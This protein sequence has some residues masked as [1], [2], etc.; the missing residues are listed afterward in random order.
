MITLSLTA[1]SGTNTGTLS[2]QNDLNTS[3]QLT[4]E[5]ADQVAETFLKAWQETDYVTMYS[6]I[7]PNSRDAYTETEFTDEYENAATQLTLITLQT[8]TIS[9]LRQGTT[10]AMMYDVTFQTE[11]FGDLTDAGRTLRLIETPAGWRIAWSRMD[12]FPELAE[13]A[14]LERSPQMPNRGNIYDRNGYVL[15]DQEGSSIVLY[16]VIQNMPSENRCIDYLS[17]LLRREREDI[18]DLFAPWNPETLFFLGEIDPETYQREQSNLIANC[19]IT[20]DDTF[21]RP[22]RRYF[23]ELAPHIVGYVAQIQPEQVE[24]YARKGYDPD[25]LIGQMGIEQSYEEYLAGKPGANLVIYA[26]TGE[27]LRELAQSDAEPGQSVYLTIDRDL[28]EAVQNAFLEAYSYSSNTWAQTSPGAA[29]VVMDVKTGEILAMVSYPGFNPA[30]FNPDY[31]GQ[32][33]GAEI[34]ALQ[35]DRRTPLLNRA[36]QS[37]HPAGSVFKIVSTAAGLDSGVYTADTHYNC[38]AVWSNP[39]DVL[40]QRYDWI[41]DYGDNHGWIDFQHALTYSCDPYYWE[42]SVHLNDTDENLLSNYAY[43]MGLGVSSGQNDIEEDVGYVQNPEEH[44]RRSGYRWSIGEAANLVIGQGQMQITPL[45]IV[46]MVAAVANGGTLW[47]PQFVDKVQLIGEEPVLDTQPIATSVLDFDPEV[48]EVIQEAMCQVTLDP[49]G[50]ARFIFEPWYQFQETDVVVCAKTGTA[51]T[52]DEIT[53]PHAWFAAFVPQ[54]DPEIAIAVIVENSCEGSE[55]SAPITRRI[56]EDYFGLPHS[57]W[58][59]LWITGCTDLGD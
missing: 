44:F 45:Q 30:L 23:A 17:G 40:A 26:P 47:T 5:Q 42:L 41:Y 29:A 7:S 19:G 15:A 54:D 27:V 22:T 14:R 33:R 59:S 31:P 56:I 25:A 13:G 28:Q 4:L 38:T 34:Q 46:R 11:V 57:E 58:P 52:G 20:A 53:K 39:R 10:A 50:T 51:Q 37:L 1:C 18:E 43:L 49:N 48:F 9:S 8:T 12:I 2:G 35:N 16:G 21:T 6:L 32:N 3:P 55:V 36:T 24:E